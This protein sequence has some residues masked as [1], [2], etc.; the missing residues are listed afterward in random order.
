VNPEVHNIFIKRIGF[1][2]IRVHR[3]Q[4]TP[5]TSSSAEVLLQQLKWPI[6][7]LF[8]GMRIKSYYSGTPS[9]VNQN[10]DK[11]FRFSQVTPT[12]R[13][14]QGWTVSKATQSVSAATAALAF[15]TVGTLTLRLLPT[16]LLP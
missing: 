11:W 7:A 13:S 10:L 3:L 6:E 16:L 14:T 9:Q 4:V 1:T 2:L 8:V 15:P 12:S 5:T